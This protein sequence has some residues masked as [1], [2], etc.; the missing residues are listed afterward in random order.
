MIK[1]RI[2]YLLVFYVKT[3]RLGS[4]V[5][6]LYCFIKCGTWNIKQSIPYIEIHRFDEFE[7]SVLQK[8][9]GHKREAVCDKYMD[10]TSD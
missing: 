1:F 9:F 2:L 4:T 6:W 3:L 7:N 8:I 10:K 5:V